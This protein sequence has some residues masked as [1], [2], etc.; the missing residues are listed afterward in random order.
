MSPYGAAKA[1]AHQLAHVYRGARASIST[2]ILYNHSHPRPE[3][4]VTR[5]ITRTVA[6]IAEVKPTGC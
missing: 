2:A 3:T 6:R 1:F 5:K 4:F